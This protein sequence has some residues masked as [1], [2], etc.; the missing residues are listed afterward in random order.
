MC[1]SCKTEVV[2]FASFETEN[3]T[4]QKEFHSFSYKSNSTRI[5]TPS[6]KKIKNPL[7]LRGLSKIAIVSTIH[8]NNITTDPRCIYSENNL[9]GS[10][11]I[12]SKKLPLPVT[13]QEEIKAALD[14]AR[15]TRKSHCLRCVT[16]LMTMFLYKF[17]NIIVKKTHVNRALTSDEE[18]MSCIRRHCSYQETFQAMI[19]TNVL[20]RFT[21][22][23]LP[24]EICETFCRVPNSH[25]VIHKPGRCLTHIISYS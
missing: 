4:H 7:T 10:S 9:V 11:E 17:E 12:T 25:K 14:S 13:V 6:L 20:C 23:F 16:I 3:E 21:S 24:S 5:N 1:D 2:D 8:H 15:I 18:G 22:D 19:R